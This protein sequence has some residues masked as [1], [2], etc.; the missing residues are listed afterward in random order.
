MK[1]ALLLNKQSYLINFTLTENVKWQKL[2][3][4]KIEVNM[5][6]LISCRSVTTINEDYISQV[7]V[8]DVVFKLDCGA[9]NITK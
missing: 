5:K 6:F 8:D 1:Q 4:I 2:R 9:L 7:V 3:I